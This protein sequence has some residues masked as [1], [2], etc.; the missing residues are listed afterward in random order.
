MMSLL[1][2]EM[3]F[4]SGDNLQLGLFFCFFNFLFSCWIIFHF[5]L[6]FT[7]IYI[8]IKPTTKHWVFFSCCFDQSHHSF[9]TQIAHEQ[10]AVE[11]H[12][13]Y[14]EQPAWKLRTGNK[15]N[16]RFTSGSVNF[17]P[18]FAGL[19]TTCRLMT[20]ISKKQNKTKQKGHLWTTLDLRTSQCTSS[21]SVS[22]S[23]ISKN[24]VDQTSQRVSASRLLVSTPQ[25]YTRHHFIT[26]PH[27]QSVIFKR[28][29]RPLSPGEREK[30]K[31]RWKLQ[32]LSPP[33]GSLPMHVPVSIRDLLIS[34]HLVPPSFLP[35]EAFSFSTAA[36]SV[37]HYS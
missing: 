28:L 37:L 13:V 32:F 36:A 17:P 18:T 6:L 5:F 34:F 19:A 33:A 9:R 15:K 27:K 1:P 20:W 21:S 14:G 23:L 12:I 29:G 31:R 10:N 25:T 16:S 30:E 24:T 2:D 7:R 22:S 8:Y 11:L 26:S 4:A 35:P 3:C